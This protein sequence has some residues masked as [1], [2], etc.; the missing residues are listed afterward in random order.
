MADA[1]AVN[2]WRNPE[3]KPR[4]RVDNA[5][6]T[7]AL[8]SASGT[9]NQSVVEVTDRDIAS[10][11]CELYVSEATRTATM[12]ATGWKPSATCAAR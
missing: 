11:A 8:E 10:R 6:T 1:I 12:R 2:P 3:A 4:R 7:G 9:P 5:V